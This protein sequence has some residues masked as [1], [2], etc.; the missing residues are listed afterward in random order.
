MAVTIR[1]IAAVA[2]VSRG[3]VD[4]VLHDRPGVRPEIAEHVREIAQKLGFE[5]NRAGKMLAGR[6]QPIKIGCFLPSVNNAFFDDVIAGFRRAEAEFSDFGVSVQLREVEGYDAET[7]LR[8]VRELAEDG[9]SALCV[10]TVDTQRMRAYIDSLADAG[11]PVVTVN[12]DLT[13]TRRLCYVGADYRKGG[14]TAA[15]LLSL[16]ARKPLNLLIVT[17]S[18]NI[19]GHKDRI[20]GFSQTLR[21]KGVSYRLVDLFESFDSDAHAYAMTMKILREHPEINCI[22]IAAAGVAGVCRAVVELDRQ[23]DLHI[24]SHDEIA[25]TLRMI[26]D[27]VIDFSIGQEPEMQGYRAIQLLFEYFMNDRRVR[28]E[29]FITGTVIRIKENLA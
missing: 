5:P 22:Y 29:N 12:N 19:K 2:G 13:G 17:G 21:E 14:R 16:M 26:R 10:S 15:G 24:F 6:K 9:C 7:H 28:P 23:K 4:R 8:A 25:V 11:I 27:G 3:T 20:R 1:Q 18:L